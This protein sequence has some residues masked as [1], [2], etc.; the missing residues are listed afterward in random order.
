MALNEFGKRLDRNGYAPSLFDLKRSTCWNCGKGG[1]T[2]RHEVFGGSRR[3]KSKELGLWVS[4]CGECHRT[5]KQAAHQSEQTA[6][7]LKRI[8]QRK[9]M[10]EYGWDMDEWMRRFYKN[11]LEEEN[12]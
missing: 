12:V 10:S 11:Y 8:A 6:S 9:A 1:D 4:L 5:G 3:T 7:F 2:E